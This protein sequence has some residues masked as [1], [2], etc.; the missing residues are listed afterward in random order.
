MGACA[1]NIICLGTFCSCGDIEISIP[2]GSETTLKMV[3]EFNGVRIKNEIT[4]ANTDKITIPNIFNEN[5][6]HIIHFVT[7]DGDVLNDEYYSIKIE[8]CIYAD[9]S[10]PE[11]IIQSKDTSIMLTGVTGKTI[12]DE[13]MN[14]KIVTGLI[15]NDNSKNSGFIKNQNEIVLTFTD[16]TTLTT[17]DFITI[18]FQK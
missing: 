13:R 7:A 9:D 8:P 4:V 18:I 12:T 10:A 3:A 1:Q 14:D 16:E 2:T 11:P 17:G 6:T 5:Y 15:I